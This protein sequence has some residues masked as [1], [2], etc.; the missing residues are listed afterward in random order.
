MSNGKTVSIAELDC[1][2]KTPTGV[3]GSLFDVKPYGVTE[4][5][6]EMRGV[7]HTPHLGCLVARKQSGTWFICHRA[8]LLNGDDGFILTN[9]KSRVVFRYRK[10]ES[11]QK[12]FFVL[13]DKDG[14]GIKQAL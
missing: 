2:K 6:S 7:F 11:L 14:E 4:I 3:S 5:S 9:R 8:K 1:Y 13:M 12:L 10:Y